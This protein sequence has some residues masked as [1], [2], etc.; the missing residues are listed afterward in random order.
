MD[1]V[2][3]LTLLEKAIQRQNALLDTAYQSMAITYRWMNAISTE[4]GQC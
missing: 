2:N 3:N 1:T 4:Y